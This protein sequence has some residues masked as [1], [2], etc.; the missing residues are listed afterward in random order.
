MKAHQLL[1]RPCQDNGIRD[2]RQQ[3][4]IPYL[5][6]E[7]LNESYSDR[8]VRDH[9]FDERIYLQLQQLDGWFL[10]NEC[11]FCYVRI[12]RKGNLN[13]EG[14]K[15]EKKWKERIIFRKH[16]VGSI[17]HMDGVDTES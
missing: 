5:L 11:V 16:A 12:D 1:S 4:H 10:Y 17:Y 8:I 7:A 13:K 2:D 6:L 3:I 15:N 9:H 14:H